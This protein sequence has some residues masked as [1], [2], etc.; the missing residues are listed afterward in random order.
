MVI[1]MD[2][3]IREAPRAT[4]PRIAMVKAASQFGHQGLRGELH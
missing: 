2:C 3:N 4:L 1:G